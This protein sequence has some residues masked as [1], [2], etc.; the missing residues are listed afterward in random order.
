MDHS[1]LIALSGTAAAIAFTHT[2]LGPDHYIPFVA[3]SKA[4]GWSPLRTLIL[5][6]LCGIG[7]CAS[8]VL[9]GAI[10]IAIGAAVGKLEWIEGFRGDLAGWLLLGFG[11]AYTAW[12]LRRAWRNRPH[13]HWH[14]HGDGT[15]H[16]HTHVHD[17]EHAHVHASDVKP[18]LTPWILFTIFVFGPCEPLIPLLMYPAARHSLAGVALVTVIFSVVTIATMTTLVMLA[19]HGLNRLPLA[20]FERYT[21]AAAGIAVTACGIA[22]TLGL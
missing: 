19:R 4:G 9:L 1:Q 22:V 7:H 8:S 16:S 12:G 3:M 6:V 20:R 5:T 21:H 15:V 13:A 10:G 2:I 18:N 11:L 17:V 14:A